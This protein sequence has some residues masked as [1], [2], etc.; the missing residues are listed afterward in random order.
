MHVRE[1]TGGGCTIALDNSIKIA[2][3]CLLGTNVLFVTVYYLDKN[4]CSK[5]VTASCFR[6]L[7]VK[8]NFIIHMI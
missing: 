4:N 8:N 5:V 3:A 6:D 7:F 2:S 1:W